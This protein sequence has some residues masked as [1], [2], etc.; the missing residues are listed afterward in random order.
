M[1]LGADGVQVGT[2]F[3]ASHEAS[4]HALFKEAVV[5]STEGSA[6]TVFWCPCSH[7]GLMTVSCD[8]IV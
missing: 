1:V 2:R 3:V 4:C 6:S 7:C 8:G 5:N